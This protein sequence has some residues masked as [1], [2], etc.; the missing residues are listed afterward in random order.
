MNK[1]R[2]TLITEYEGHFGE[3]FQKEAQKDVQK[4]DETVVINDI[5]RWSSNNHIPPEDLLQLWNHVG[6]NFN[7]DAAIV[8]QDIEVRESIEQYKIHRRNHPLNDE[9]L[10]EIVA[11]FGVGAEVV[12]I[13]TGE[14]IPI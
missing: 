2:R 8:Q 3:F 14:R 7:L 11:T 6:K 1:V 4:F 9:E 13:L 10:Q 12:D 5:P